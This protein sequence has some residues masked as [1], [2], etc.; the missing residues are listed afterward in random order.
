MAIDKFGSP[1]SVSPFEDDSDMPSSPDASMGSSVANLSTSP[2]SG[3][4]PITTGMSGADAASLGGAGVGAAATTAKAILNSIAAQNS[5]DF[6]SSQHGLDRQSQGAIG[7][8]NRLVKAQDTSMQTARGSEGNQLQAGRTQVDAALGGQ[9]LS[10][11]ATNA[12]VDSLAQIMGGNTKK[13]FG[14]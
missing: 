8:Q 1:Y 4:P 9:G 2:G 11:K 12:L 5:I 13:R 7:G 3:A 10:D 6:A 14:A